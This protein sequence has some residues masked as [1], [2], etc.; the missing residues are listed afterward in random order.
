MSNKPVKGPL[1]LNVLDSILQEHQ[2]P[3]R[4]A[5]EVEV[6][7]YVA[8]YHDPLMGEIEACVRGPHV[9]MY[10]QDLKASPI[11]IAAL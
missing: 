2:I 5:I 6:Q 4:L 3:E 1:E 10:E 7:R 9:Q 11:N 8:K